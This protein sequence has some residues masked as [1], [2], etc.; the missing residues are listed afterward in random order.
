MKTKILY[1]GNPYLKEDNLAVLVCRKLKKELNIDF[2]EVK[3]TF[4]LIGKN[5][6]NSIIIDVVQGIKKVQ[7]IDSETLQR[8]NITSLHD[9]DL[10]FFLSLLKL[11]PRIL[12]IPQNYNEEKA[13]EETRCLIPTLLSG[14]E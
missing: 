3:D 12:G 2:E 13:I 11:K 1:F 5:Q 7:I 6:D 10:S 14:N 9:F 4:Q 8:G